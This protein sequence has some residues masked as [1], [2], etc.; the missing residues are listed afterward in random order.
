MIDLSSMTASVVMTGLFLSFKET[1]KMGILGVG[2]LAL[3]IPKL[4]LTVSILGLIGYG[5]YKTT[6]GK[7]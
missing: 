1:R 6:G 5:I 7:R 3:A 2:L 4:F